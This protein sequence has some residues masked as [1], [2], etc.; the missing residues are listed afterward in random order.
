M[1]L[2]EYIKRLESANPKQEV[3]LGLGNPHSWRGSYAELAFEPVKNTTI[4]EMLVEAKKAI[5]STYEGYKGGNYTMTTN[6]TINVE[7]YGEWTDGG[8]L[9]EMFLDLLLSQ[10]SGGELHG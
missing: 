8:Q 3:S 7:Y 4:G 2:G 1:T 10:N 5:G 9:W 6:T